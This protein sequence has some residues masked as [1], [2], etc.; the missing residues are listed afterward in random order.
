MHEVEGEHRCSAG[1]N[2]C[3]AEHFFQKHIQRRQHQHADQGPGKAPA[4]GR[5]PEQP[6]ADAQD[7][8]AQRRVADL[9]GIEVFDV[10]IGRACVIDLVKIG[11]VSVIVFLRDPILLIKQRVAALRPGQLLRGQQ[12]PVRGVE[13]QLPKP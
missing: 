12:T 5:H 11:T 6:D 7:Q 8:L 4:E 2:R 9:I 13:R 3:P 1:W 10:L